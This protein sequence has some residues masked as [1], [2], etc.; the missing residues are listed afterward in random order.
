MRTVRRQTFVDCTQH[1]HLPQAPWTHMTE[2]PEHQYHRNGVGGRERGGSG[3]VMKSFPRRE[4]SGEGMRIGITA[5]VDLGIVSTHICH[6]WK[7]PQ[8]PQHLPPCSSIYAFI[9]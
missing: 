6:S 8:A 1:P 7:H 4:N 2:D 9:Q 5:V 3:V